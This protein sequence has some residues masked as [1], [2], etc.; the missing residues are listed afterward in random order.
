MPQCGLNSRPGHRIFIAMEADMRDRILVLAA[1]AAIWVAGGPFAVPQARA[2]DE[3]GLSIT[4]TVSGIVGMGGELDVALFNNAK[5]WLDESNVPV[6]QKRLKI[7]S[8]TMRVTFEGLA[9]SNYAVVVY[10]DANGNKELDTGFMGSPEEG[11]AFSGEGEYGFGPPSFEESS[12]TLFG[13]ST[14]VN[15]RMTYPE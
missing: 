3:A 10:H 12:F 7:K 9:A 14:A 4:L 1:I 15:V 11:H 2:G 8:G 13:S 6:E 5:F